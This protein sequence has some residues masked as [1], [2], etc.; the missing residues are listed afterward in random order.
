MRNRSGSA[1]SCRGRNRPGEVH[2]A[3]LRPGDI[4]VRLHQAYPIGQPV[5]VRRLADPVEHERRPIDGD[6][7][8]RPEV[9]REC[10]G[11][12]SRAGPDV[13][14][15]ARAVQGERTEPFDHLL[16]VGA[17]HLG[18]QIQ[19]LGQFGLVV[20]CPPVGAVVMLAVVMPMV[21]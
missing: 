9:P 14:D 10:Q 6:E 21:L 13:D 8:S 17:E 7:L 4:E 15:R 2:R 5:G 1:S 20:V 12:R 3:D 16:Q 18:V 11:C 19:Q